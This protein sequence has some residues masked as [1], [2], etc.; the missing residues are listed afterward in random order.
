MT[1]RHRLF[2]SYYLGVS[3]GNATD[4]ARRAGYPWPDKQGPRLLQFPTIKA[5]I[6]AKLA[7]FVMPQE[8]VLAR[9]SEVAGGDITKFITVTG[10][11][12]RL[13]PRK[14]KR[15]GKVAIRK[16]KATKDGGEIELEPK[17]A[18]LIKLGEY[19]GMWDK[20]PASDAATDSGAEQESEVLDDELDAWAAERVEGME[21]TPDRPPESGG[22]CNAGEQEGVSAPETSEDSEFEII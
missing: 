11:R 22:L 5:A 19:H 4:A 9:L 21:E 12:W 2:V 7:E 17:L 6:D 14:I 16:L 3:E 8:E 10:D 1:W 20:K 18:A 15:H 13:D